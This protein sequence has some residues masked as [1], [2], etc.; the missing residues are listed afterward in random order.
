M[1]KKT[2]IWV[3]EQIKENKELLGST[4]V[5]NDCREGKCPV[6]TAQVHRLQLDVVPPAHSP[7][8]LVKTRPLMIQ[9]KGVSIKWAELSRREVMM[10]SALRR[11]ERR[12]DQPGPRH[13]RPIAT[14]WA[15]CRPRPPGSGERRS[16]RQWAGWIGSYHWRWVSRPFPAMR[17]K[18]ELTERR[19]HRTGHRRADRHLPA[20]GW[21]RR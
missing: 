2:R 7:F 10:T 5:F 19:K 9:W 8:L 1:I 17:C 20:S 18:W 21:P 12:K 3:T 4:L 11:A 13:R 6:V 15:S 14:W 16:C